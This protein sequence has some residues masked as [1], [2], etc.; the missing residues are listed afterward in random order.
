MVS[1]PGVPCGAPSLSFLGVHN[2]ARIHKGTGS[3]PSPVGIPGSY[4]SIDTFP[5]GQPW[6]HNLSTSIGCWTTDAT[7]PGKECAWVDE[8]VYGYFEV[9]SSTNFQGAALWER[10]CSIQLYCALPLSKSTSWSMT[11]TCSGP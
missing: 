3:C 1:V 8:G 7:Y 6:F 9:C 11:V 5:Y 4:T 2:T 10:S